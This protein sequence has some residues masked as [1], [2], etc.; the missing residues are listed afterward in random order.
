MVM[1][2]T[3]RRLRINPHFII[4]ETLTRPEAKIMELGGVAAGSIKA[5][6][7]AKVVGIMRERGGIPISL[8]TEPTMGKKSSVVDVLLVNSVRKVMVKV[9]P[10]V[11]IHSG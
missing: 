10:K 5:Q 8:E 2:P 6:E 3:Q 1:M 4:S 9:M 11:I 7:A